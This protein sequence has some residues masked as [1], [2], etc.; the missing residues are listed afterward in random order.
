MPNSKITTAPS[1]VGDMNEAQLRREA[2]T[3]DAIRNGKCIG[4]YDLFSFCSADTPVRYRFTCLHEHAGIV[5]ICKRHA[6]ER[7]VKACGQ[8]MDSDSAHAFCPVTV[9]KDLPL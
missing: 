8:C 9:K 7:Y 1:A 4:S 6:D 3:E 2:I 5:L